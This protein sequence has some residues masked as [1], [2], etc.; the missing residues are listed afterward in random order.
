M[1]ATRAE[2]VRWAN[3][4]AFLAV[5]N[6]EKVCSLCVQAA[7]RASR[8]AA[9]GASGAF[10]RGVAAAA[11]VAERV[12]PPAIVDAQPD[13]S[14][15]KAIKNKGTRRTTSVLRRGKNGRQVLRKGRAGHHLIAS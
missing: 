12:S 5:K 2:G 15:A 8:S 3:V 14:A 11:G 10:V 4:S 9:V 7:N 1:R 6:L 13:T